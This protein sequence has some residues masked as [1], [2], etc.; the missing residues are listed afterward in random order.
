METE[1]ALLQMN[2]QEILD[3]WPDTVLVFIAYRMICVGC[4]MA[5]FVRLEE[6]L[7][8]YHIPPGP[9]LEHLQ[10]SLEDPGGGTLQ[11]EA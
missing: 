9:F 6:A 7:H 5:A 3:R 4:S 10:R 8:A 11:S 1:A 2:V